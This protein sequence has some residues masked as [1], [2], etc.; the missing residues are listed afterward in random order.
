[1]LTD[2][3]KLYKTLSRSGVFY[4]NALWATAQFLW[5]YLYDGSSLATLAKWAALRFP[6]QIAVVEDDKK[7]TFRGLV[8]D[9]EGV[10]AKLEQ[11]FGMTSKQTI[12]LLGRNS[13]DFIETLLACEMVG[14][15]ILLFHVN[16]IAENLKHV[17]GKQTIDFLIYDDEFEQLVQSVEKPFRTISFSTL[18]SSKHTKVS[19]EHTKSSL[20][21]LGK[22]SHLILFTSGTTG[23]PK[24]IKQRPK[25]TLK[26]LAG[27][28]ERLDLRANSRTLLTLP[29]SHGHGLATLAFGLLF[30]STLYVFRKSNTERFVECIQQEKIDVLVLVPTI[31]YRLL[32]QPKKIQVMKLIS[33]SAP[34]DERIAKRALATYGE[35]L[36]NLYGSSEVG[37]ISLATPDDL[38]QNPATVGK[39]LPGVILKIQN[40]H[41]YMMKHGLLLDTGDMGY[42]DDQKNLFLL[43]RSDDLLICGGNNIHPQMIEKKV[44][45]LGY[46]EEC[47]A[48]GVP[49]AEY[50]QA[51]HLYV[52][53]KEQVSR[54]TLD[55][56]IKQ[57]FPKSLRAQEI[58]M[59]ST[60]PKTA[61]G[62][63]ER[64]KLRDQQVSA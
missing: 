6:N 48:L 35:R 38:R 7:V 53:L 43:G 5:V 44:N 64:Y 33:G 49:D 19:S 31:L 63:I 9:A 34:L 36:Y 62:K 37:L 55:S 18:V 51:V 8:E 59:V 3:Y 12:G 52:V 47:A 20:L 41:I 15:T 24:V 40:N 13:I 42:L 60:L 21:R 10:A 25:L 46:I 32:E 57:L 39:V 27:L 2:V 45:G 22:Q 1:M 14:A 26:T 23:Q 17:Q 30:G 56:D 58:Y 50:G 4:P 11:T 54:A 29:L 61:S 28:L 16:F